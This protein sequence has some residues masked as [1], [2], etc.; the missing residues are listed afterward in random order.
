MEAARRLPSSTF[1]VTVV[2]SGAA[3]TMTPSAPPLAK[4][5]SSSMT[6]VLARPGPSIAQPSARTAFFSSAALR[7]SANGE[8]SD[9]VAIRWMPR[10]SANSD[11]AWTGAPQPSTPVATTFSP[12]SRSTVSRM[13]C[14][15]GCDGSR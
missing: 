5:P 10:A 4:T 1:S 7:N 6:T 15:S 9:A 3:M 14:C 8:E 12:V 11:I 13:C 2:P